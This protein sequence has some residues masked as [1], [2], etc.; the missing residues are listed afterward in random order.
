MTPAILS[1]LL[2]DSWHITKELPCDPTCETGCSF[3]N[4]TETYYQIEEKRVSVQNIFDI[5][6]RCLSKVI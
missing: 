2:Q 6:L 5:D 4:E 1:P 3:N